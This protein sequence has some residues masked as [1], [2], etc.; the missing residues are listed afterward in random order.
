MRAVAQ[1]LEVVLRADPL[2]VLADQSGHH[3]HVVGGVADRDPPRAEQVAG[4]GDARPVQH[5]GRD[6]APLGVREDPVVGVVAQ[7]QVVHRLGLGA[8]ARGLQGRLQG[9]DQ[10]AEV[11]R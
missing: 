4:R 11:A 7:H 10:V 8:D 2:A 6:L 1:L 3:V 9:R 5:V